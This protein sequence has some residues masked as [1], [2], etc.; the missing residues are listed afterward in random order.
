MG[1]RRF[2][3][4]SW[5]AKPLVTRQTTETAS[6]GGLIVPMSF[7]ALWQVKVGEML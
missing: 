4:A 5:R 3:R 7:G 1:G 6:Y 2:L